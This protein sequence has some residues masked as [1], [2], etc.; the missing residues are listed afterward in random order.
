MNWLTDSWYA[1]KPHW[2]L[3]FLIPLSLIYRLI[4]VLRR[5]AYNIGLFKQTTLPVPVIIVGNITVGGT[6]KTPAVIWLANVLT[7][8]GY[9]P[10]IISRGYGGQADHYPQEVTPDSDPAVVGDE[11]VIIS[12]QTGCVMAVS[13]KRA[14]AAQYLIQQ[15][16]CDVI[17]SDD[18]LQH[19]A[20]GR[21]IEIVIIDG[22]RL[23]GN[24]H[25]L[26]AGP[27]REPLSRLK[28]V[29]FTIL[30]GSHNQHYYVMSLEPGLA[31]NI[32]DNTRQ[33]A[34]I[35]FEQ[36]PIH[37]I[38]GI[39]NPDRFFNTLRQQNLTI[40]PHYF[41][42]HHGFQASDID[43]KDNKPIIMTEKDAIK[44]RDFATDNMWYIPVKAR[45]DKHLEQ[46]ILTKLAGY[47]SNG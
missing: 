47:Q 5:L 9:T 20:L 14:E 26:P 11:P 22:Q 2:R 12:Q 23:F 18:G 3:I 41:A 16:H 29:D 1:S 4:T 37:A 44:C 8:A 43:F 30:N 28:K 46:H 33:Q 31:I 32:A 21:D 15:H 34:V 27:L 36:Q 10:G 24:R 35:A 42:D 25:C 40:T 39:G 45:I 17:I 6:G 7:Q 19:Y 38:A 13:P